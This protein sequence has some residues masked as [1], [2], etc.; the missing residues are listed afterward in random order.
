MSDRTVVKDWLAKLDTDLAFLMEC[1]REVLT[2]LG[3]TELASSLP[4]LEDTGSADTSNS[5]DLG[6]RELQVLSIAFQL[7][8]L[9]EENAAAQARRTRENLGALVH[10]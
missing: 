8:N 5:T 7:L 10:E 2:K 6:A 3:E 4:W 1:F 9:V